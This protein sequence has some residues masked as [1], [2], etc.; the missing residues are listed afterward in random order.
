VH[1]VDF[2]VLQRGQNPDLP[3]LVTDPAFVQSNPVNGLFEFERHTPKD[4]M[5]LGPS[6]E[7]F[8]IAR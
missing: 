3:A 2:F 8:V 4:V 5:F 1:L 6:Q 7:L